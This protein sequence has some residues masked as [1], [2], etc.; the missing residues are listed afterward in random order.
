M[1]RLLALLVLVIAFN[2]TFA[3]STGH[4]EIKEIRVEKGDVYVF[5]TTTLANGQECGSASPVKLVPSDPGFKE[6]YSQALAA[7]SSGKKIK[8][9]VK[10]CGSSPWGY[11]I[12]V[13]YAAGIYK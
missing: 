9:W 11:T 10:E 2:S 5:P 6:M 12:P 8:Y 3:A 1:I 7:L 13:A 4:F